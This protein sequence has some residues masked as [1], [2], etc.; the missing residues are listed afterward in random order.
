MDDATAEVIADLQLQD[1]RALL[2]HAKLVGNPNDL[3][4]AFELQLEELERAQTAMKDRRLCLSIAQAVSADGALLDEVNAQQ[5]QVNEDRDLAINLEQDIEPAAQPQHANMAAA[6]TL[7]GEA[8]ARF[9]A[10][11]HGAAATNCK[12]WN[13]GRT[14]EKVILTKVSGTVLGYVEV[15]YGDE[16]H[17]YFRSRAL[18]E[19]KAHATCQVCSE[20]APCTAMVQNSCSH[21][22]C[23]SCI[24]HH[25]ELAT[26]D[27][28]VYP[29]QCCRQRIS[30]A[31][32]RDILGEQRM[33]AF[34]KKAVEFD[35][36][37]RIY[38]PNVQCRAFIPPTSYGVGNSATCPMCGIPIC[39]LCK[40][41]AHPGACDD[42]IDSEM[43]QASERA[44]FMRCKRC[45]HMIELK[46]GCDHITY[47]YQPRKLNI[48]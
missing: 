35:T 43:L 2:D 8:F 11:N 1:T 14:L 28:D 4:V 36:P 34:E 12:S 16:V 29:P 32:V 9:L 46:N 39:K 31:S 10:L 27:E 44:G 13:D 47:V 22:F 23:Q 33:Q 26:V 18:A 20:E 5:H 30:P 3:G 19:D 17:L 48:D 15:E 6:P 38:C 25:F 45:L 7:S 21:W 40:R 24:R 41:K 42:D 37:N